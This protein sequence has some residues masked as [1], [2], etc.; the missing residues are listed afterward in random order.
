MVDP[1]F[2]TTSTRA[3]VWLALYDLSP[4]HPSVDVFS[5][6]QTYVRSGC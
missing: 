4:S 3:D 6:T 2:S 1:L 5:L